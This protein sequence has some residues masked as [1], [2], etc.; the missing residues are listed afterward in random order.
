MYHGWKFDRTGTCVDMPSEPPDSLFKT[1]VTVDAYPT[2]EGGDMIWAYL[3]PP[4]HKPAPP[5]HELL[6][7]TPGHRFV[8]KSLEECNFLQALEGGID[9]THATIMHNGHI[10][11]RSF[12]NNYDALVADLNLD[13]T[14]YASPTPA[15]GRAQGTRGARYRGSCRHITCARASRAAGP[16]VATRS[17]TIGHI[18]IRSTTRNVGVQLHVLHDPAQ[19]LP[20]EQAQHAEPTG[21]GDYLTKLR[22]ETQPFERRGIDRHVKS[23]SMTGIPGI[24]TQDFARRGM[25]R[26]SRTKEHVGTTDRA[27][28][29]L[30]QILF[31]SLD[32]LDRGGQL[33]AIDPATYRN[34]RSIDRMVKKE[35]DWRLETRADFVAKF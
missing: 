30:R 13:R 12:L 8:S 24:N 20:R 11:D 25:G 17:A 33:K 28:I 26:S 27:I 1:K 29:I 22:L 5:D 3:G 21:R 23:Q 16:K 34:V 31:E 2:W 6:R 7:T 18:W 32:T 14:D 9:P 19:P 35:L 10:G 4:E 15:C